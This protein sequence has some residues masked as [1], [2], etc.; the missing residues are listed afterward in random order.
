LGALFPDTYPSSTA[1][2]VSR[3]V[4]TT[5]TPFDGTKTSFI[6]EIEQ[7]L[8]VLFPDT[9]PAST[10]LAISSRTT[11]EI[12]Y[13]TD[14]RL[15][16]SVATTR[17]PLGVLFPIIYPTI[18][19]LATS[20][21][22][23]TTYAYETTSAYDVEKITV[24]QVVIVTRQPLGVI[25]PIIYPSSTSLSDR[26]KETTTYTR[27]NQGYS[28]DYWNKN[29]SVLE[30]LGIVFPTTYPSST[31]LAPSSNGA[32]DDTN[33]DGSCTAPAVTYRNPDNDIRERELKTAVVV[34]LPWEDVYR[35][36]Q[37]SITVDFCISNAQIYQYGLLFNKMLVGRSYGATLT[38]PLSNFWLSSDAR[39]FC[40]IQVTHSQFGE[41]AT[42]YR[43]KLDSITW[44]LNGTEAYAMANLILVA[45]SA[46]GGGTIAPIVRAIPHATLTAVAG[47]A[48]TT[49]FYY[50]GG[51]KARAIAILISLFEP[52][53]LPYSFT[54]SNPNAFTTFWV[55]VSNPDFISIHV[56]GV[57][58][59]AS[60]ELADGT[61]LSNPTTAAEFYVTGTVS[62]SVQI[63]FT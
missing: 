61:A 41:T 37:R 50:N 35:P 30:P 54:D 22:T 48:T 47:A 39:P 11:T 32:F 46:G 10:S 58:F 5:Y 63:D 44:A 52:Q 8:G 14:G 33:N 3:K 13:L 7:P 49:S 36:R 34:E 21:V 53:F 25:F 2:T 16:Y 42:V 55:K 1:L 62:G 28:N 38:T 57:G 15:S 60:L 40:E 27:Y 4:T 20:E 6:Q 9:Y 45:K 59:T 56:A 18:T 23:T 43:Y 24:K 51:T 26:K 29:V 17:Q 31:S 12:Y 19:S